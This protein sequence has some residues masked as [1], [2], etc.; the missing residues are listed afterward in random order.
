MTASSSA[1]FADAGGVPMSGLLREVPEPRA[2][3]VALHGGA[4]TSGYFDSRTP[5]LS[6]LRT[7]AALGFTVLALDRPGYGMSAAYPEELGSAERRVDLAYAAVDALLGTRP[8]GAGLFLMAHSMGC[9]L[10]IRMAGHERGADLLG[11]EIAGTGLEYQPAA[12]AALG[13]RMAAGPGRSGVRDAIWGPPHLYPPG[14]AAGVDSPSPDYE[15]GEVRS[16]RAEFPAAAAQVR[17]P[18]HITLGEHEQVWQAGPPALASLAALFTASPRVVAEEQPGAGHNLSLGWSAL[19]YHLRV[20]AF[21]E[22]CVLARG[23]ADS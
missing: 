4:A 10:A 7:G 13:A 17:V 12:A 3:I 20:L 15:G 5:R 1:P 23:S 11:L 14:A 9:V 6:L 2:V 21:A 8:R 18:V 19:A 16:W 22:E